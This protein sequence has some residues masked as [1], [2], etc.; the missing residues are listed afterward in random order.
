MVKYNFVAQVPSSSGSKVYTIKC[1]EDGLFSCSCPA[2]IFNVRR[3]RTCKHI[4]SLRKD[5]LSIDGQGRLLTAVSRYG[6]KI[7]FLC[8]T[9]PACEDCSMRF[10]C[11]T[12]EEA[13]F[14]KD[15]LIEKG[16]YKQPW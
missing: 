5:G 15:T 1:K 16:L 4:D 7:K 2:W 3:N 6:H 11:W 10:D 8:K 14:P 12:S 13:E 9:Y